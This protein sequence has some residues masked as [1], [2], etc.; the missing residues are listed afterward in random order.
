MTRSHAL[1]LAPG[2]RLGTRHYIGKNL[3]IEAVAKV[4]FLGQ[5]WNTQFNFS[6]DHD[7]STSDPQPHEASYG[8]LIYYVG[9]SFYLCCVERRK[10]FLV[11][12][13][14]SRVV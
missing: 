9:S 13:L 3:C 6:S 14:E 5:H 1:I 10:F 11:H 4:E 12:K 8:V 2:S 7:I